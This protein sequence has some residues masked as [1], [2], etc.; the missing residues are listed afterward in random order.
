[1]EKDEHIDGEGAHEQHEGH[2]TRLSQ[3]REDYN[4]L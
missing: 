1:M 3:Q 4:E 2:A